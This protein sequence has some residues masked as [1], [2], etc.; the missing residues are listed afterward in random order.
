MSL[1]VASLPNLLDG[2]SR[3]SCPSH[4]TYS[5]ETV[6][7]KKNL[8]VASAAILQPLTITLTPVRPCALNYS[9]S[10]SAH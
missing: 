9:L 6:D 10:V 5:V 4:G 7:V 2:T 8:V 3:I 1:E